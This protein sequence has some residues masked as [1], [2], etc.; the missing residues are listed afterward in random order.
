MLK[1]KST[2]ATARI[3][4]RRTT[5]EHPV[6]DDDEERRTATGQQGTD[7]RRAR[8]PLAR[9]RSHSFEAGAGS[10]TQMMWTLANP[11]QRLRTEVRQLDVVQRLQARSKDARWTDTRLRQ[12]ARRTRSDGWKGRNERRVSNL[13]QHER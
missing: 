9:S 4:R 8:G 11:G 5:A 10:S 3:Q 12:L 13:Q 1:R 7:M 6:D 2:A